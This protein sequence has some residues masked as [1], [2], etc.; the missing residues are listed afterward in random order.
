MRK[1]GIFTI[2]TETQDALGR[3]PIAGSFSFAARSF[4]ARPR[5]ALLLAVMVCTSLTGCSKNT[6]DLE[7]D[8]ARKAMD[9]ASA[10]KASDCATATYKAA[11]TALNE[12]QKLAADGKIDE[13]KAKAME[14]ETLADQAALASPPGCDE[15]KVA[16]PDEPAQPET[17]DASMNLSIESA[18][19]N[20]IYFDY[21]DASIRED[22]KAVLEDVAALLQKAPATR[23]EVEGHCDVRGSTEYNLHLGERRATSVKKYL[24]AHGVEPS[25]VAVI[26]YGEERPVDLGMSEEAHQ[27]NRRAEL[28]RQ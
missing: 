13:A 24:T 12:A 22:S 4:A 21:N 9:K 19:K 8:A 18:L 28:K 6:A 23:I 16:T 25:H 5:A 3:R 7:L 20:V 2:R 27:K 10:Q 15:P 26:S 17:T 14:A 1:F 11:E